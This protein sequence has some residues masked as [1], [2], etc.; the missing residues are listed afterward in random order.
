MD[1]GA[2]TTAVEIAL[3]KLQ[4]SLKAAKSGPALPPDVQ[5]ALLHHQFSEG[6]RKVLETQKEFSKPLMVNSLNGRSGFQSQFVAPLLLREA[7]HRGSADVAVR[8]LEKVLATRSG[9]GIAVCTLWGIKPAQTVQLAEGIE[10]LPFD[11][12]PASRQKVS[13]TAVQWP[14]STSLSLAAPPYTWEP[15]TA[16]LVAQHEIEPY[17]SAVESES[18]EQKRP[19]YHARFDD[20][21]LCM[22]VSGPCAI[23]QGPVWFQYLDPDLEAAVLGAGTSLIHREVVPLNIV[24][25]T[26]FDATKASRL[27]QG[28]EGLE[29]KLK[30]RVRTAMERLHQALMRSSPSDKA[31]EISIALETLLVNETGEHTFKI[32][33]RAALLT[34]G[35]MKERS[36]SRA[37]IE[38]AYS[39]RSALMHKGDTP[40]ERN[41]RGYGSRPSTQVAA[42]AVELTALV[43]QRVIAG[44]GLPNWDMF[45]LSNGVQ[46]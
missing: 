21:F 45:E 10:L 41:L 39:L 37:T 2:L 46:K 15:P 23:V 16:A 24:A 9:S 13:L 35:D 30:S 34:S 38:A 22:A 20:I 18:T 32:A 6:V 43:I 28:Y 17:L 4:D 11:S 3:A 26:S 44:G 7:R 40:A 31:L 36:R 5:D 29:P 42:D 27:L 12:L 1:I 8:W 14:S 33:L 25:N 19:N